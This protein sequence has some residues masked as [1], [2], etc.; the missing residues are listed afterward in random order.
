MDSIQILGEPLSTDHQWAERRA[1]ID[2]MPH[3]TVNQWRTLFEQD[4]TSLGIVRP[5][6]VLD[7]IIEPAEREWKPEWQNLFDQLKLFGEPQKPLAK[8][9]YK[10]SY[11][12]EC[13]DSSKPH[14]V[15][16]EDWELG[17]L[18][19]KEVDRLGSEEKAAQSVRYKF[20]NDLCAPDKDT[21]FFM[22]TI[23]PYNTWVVLGVFYPP[24]IA[25]LS[26]F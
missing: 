26:L 4:Q 13:E 25:Q 23:F 8:I 15:M 14:T 7:M 11:V 6:R 9:P 18:F 12:F 10:F 2:R 19:L 5:A 3:R 21:R 1:V 20:F 24:K 16:C 17:V 22:G